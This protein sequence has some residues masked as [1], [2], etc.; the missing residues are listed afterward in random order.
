M[1]RT[2]ISMSVAAA[3]LLEAGYSLLG[4]KNILSDMEQPSPGYVCADK[5][6]E[7]VAQIKFKKECDR[8]Q[9]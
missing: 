1:I 7:F 8:L 9:L 5:V 2:G 4:V 6:R 3:Q